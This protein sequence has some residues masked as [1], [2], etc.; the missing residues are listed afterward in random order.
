MVI[1]GQGGVMECYE[2]LQ[3]FIPPPHTPL[4]EGLNINSCSALSANE[5]SVQDSR[6]LQ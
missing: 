6:A 4:L 2:G 1:E 5:G 3:G